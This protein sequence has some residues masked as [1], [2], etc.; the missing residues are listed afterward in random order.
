[1]FDPKAIERARQAR[2]DWEARDPESLQIHDG[3]LAAA[4]RGPDAFREWVAGD[5][6]GLL[7]RRM[8]RIASERPPR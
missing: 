6:A 8:D 7:R 3:F 2:A 4:G 5:G 1:M